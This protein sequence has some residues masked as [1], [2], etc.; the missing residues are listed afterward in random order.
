MRRLAIIGV[1]LIGGSLALA[2]KRTGLVEQ[3][4]GAGRGQANLALAL[5]NGVIDALAESP[6][7]AVA[8]ADVVVLAV[9]VGGMPALMARIAPVMHDDMVLT[10]V[11]STKQGVVAAA[12]NWL[13]ARVGQFVPAHPIAGAEASGVA[14]AHADLFRG[15]DV[16][17]TPLPE[18]TDTAVA[19]VR[20]LWQGCGAHVE[21]MTPLDHDRVFAAVS[22]LPHLAAFALMD[23]LANRE[24]SALYFRHAGPGFR[25]FTRIA[26][27]HPEMWRDI[28]LANREPLVAEL[29]A[30]IV[31]LARIRDLVAAGDGDALMTILNRASQARQQWAQG[32]LKT[33]R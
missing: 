27:S 23:E 24:N 12:R 18:N 20:A 9:P 17:L 16:I 7:A 4:V 28:A 25:D 33:P 32:K 5:A 10:D 13:G 30:Y 26:G 6:E 31:R 29:D 22:H 19:R 15:K 2:L 14:A 8:G 3:V 21:V 11:G 1:G